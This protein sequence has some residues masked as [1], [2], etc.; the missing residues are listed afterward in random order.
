MAKTEHYYTEFEEGCFYHI[1]NRAIGNGKLFNN[2]DNYKY[3]LKK[4]DEYLSGFVNLYAYC[5]LG[6]HF[7]ILVEIP[8]Y[9][10]ILNSSDTF[11]KNNL[12]KMKSLQ[13]KT[14]IKI[15]AHKII[16]HQFQKFFQSY[17]MAYNKQQNRVGTLFQTPFKRV[18]INDDQYFTNMIY[19]I[20]ANPQKHGI[21]KDF[22][23]YQWSSYQR[24]LIEKPTKLYKNEVLAWFGGKEAYIQ[25]HHIMSPDLP[26]QWIINDF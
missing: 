22:K 15:S 25:Y 7:H 5:L 3:F 8:P 6:N 20:H 21:I 2:D 9:T 16:S 12:S 23:N 10:T 4:F 26:K 19:Y 17:A 11:Q 13:S 18:L 24:I 1:Y 14:N